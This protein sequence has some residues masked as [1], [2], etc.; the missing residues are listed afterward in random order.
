MRY[1]FFGAAIAVLLPLLSVGTASA[2]FNVYYY[3]GDRADVRA[4]CLGSEGVLL[5]RADYTFCE[6]KV[7]GASRT[8]LDTGDCIGTSFSVDTTGSVRSHPGVDVAPASTILPN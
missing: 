5:D 7:T 6:D 2:G 3:Q 1:K 8:C 4:Y